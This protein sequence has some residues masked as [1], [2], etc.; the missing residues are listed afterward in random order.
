MTINFLIF[1]LIPSKW[2]QK[3]KI[4]HLL[5]CHTLYF[6]K[7]KPAETILE[8]WMPPSQRQREMLE[9]KVPG[10]TPPWTERP[11]CQGTWRSS[12]GGDTKTWHRGRPD[13]CPGWRTCPPWS[14]RSRIV[15]S[16]QRPFTEYFYYWPP[17]LPSPPGLTWAMTSPAAQRTPVCNICDLQGYLSTSLE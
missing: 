5:F 12:P 2:A 13:R 17:R 6:P 11:S 4:H 15:F 8:E 16:Q 7:L 14:A 10:P 1:R 9:R 3:T